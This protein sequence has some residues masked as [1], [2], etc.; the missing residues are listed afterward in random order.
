MQILEQTCRLNLQSCKKKRSNNVFLI[1]FDSFCDI[2]CCDCSCCYLFTLP[3]SLFFFIN[4]GWLRDL[5][6]QFLLSRQYF[7]SRCFYYILRKL[8]RSHSSIALLQS[9]VL[10]RYFIEWV[11]EQRSREYSTQRKQS[12]LIPFDSFYNQHLL[13]D[14]FVF[15]DW[16][17]SFYLKFSIFRAFFKYRYVKVCVC[18]FSLWFYCCQFVIYLSLFGLSFFVAICSHSPFSSFAT[19]FLSLKFTSHLFFVVLLLL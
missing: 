16:L 5:W 10:F 12:N 18:V 4:H 6:C 14:S 15:V 13:N 19:K 2:C 9:T 1:S 7:V 17:I 8:S 11:M 3:L